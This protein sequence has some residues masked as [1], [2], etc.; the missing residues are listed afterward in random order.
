MDGS[1]QWSNVDE[2][3]EAGTNIWEPGLPGG[4]FQSPKQPG[5]QMLRPGH[6]INTRLIYSEHTMT[7]HR[8]LAGTETVTEAVRRLLSLLSRNYINAVAGTETVTDS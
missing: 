7:I 3:N 4:L 6:A 1:A 8:V 5:S 2:N